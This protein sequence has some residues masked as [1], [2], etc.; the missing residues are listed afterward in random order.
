MQQ[1]I[2]LALGTDA[3]TVG[4]A[5]IMRCTLSVCY[6][7]I[8]NILKMLVP[9]QLTDRSMLYSEDVVAVSRS[10]CAYCSQSLCLVYSEEISCNRLGFVFLFMEQKLAETYKAECAQLRCSTASSHT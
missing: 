6:V 9:V 2:L 3:F 5:M 1:S 7:S 4:T 8:C 10:N